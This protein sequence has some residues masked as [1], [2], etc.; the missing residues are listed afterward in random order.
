ML[1]DGSDTKPTVLEDARPAKK[2]KTRC[3][4]IIVCA[5]PSVV[6]Y[7]NLQKAVL[8]NSTC[9]FYCIAACTFNLLKSL[10]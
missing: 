5:A 2:A 1:E 4:T 9:L 8:I 7:S 3:A 6:S 10:R